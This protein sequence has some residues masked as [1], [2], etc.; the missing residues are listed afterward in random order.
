METEKFIENITL[1]KT[2]GK[3]I[4]I[5]KQLRVSF[6]DGEYHLH[7]KYVTTT[8]TRVTGTEDGAFLYLGKQ[9]VG[10]L[11]VGCLTNEIEYND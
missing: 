8:F 2:S 7:D 5:G 1:A 9:L 3:L 11:F 10:M 4:T 6:D